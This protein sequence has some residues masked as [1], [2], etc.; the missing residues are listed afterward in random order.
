MFK[1]TLIITLSFHVLLLLAGCFCR[2]S[3]VKMARF[4][5]TDIKFSYADYE[6][7]DSTLFEHADTTA[8]FRG[9]SYL[10]KIGFNYELIAGNQKCRH[11]GLFNEAYACKCDEDRYEQ[12]RMIKSVEMKM[13]TDFDS[14]H[15]RNSTATD[16]FGSPFYSGFYSTAIAGFK[17]FNIDSLGFAEIS[18]RFI[19]SPQF[20]AIPAYLVKKP[21]LDSVQQ[22]EVTV[23]FHDGTT[24]TAT[25]AP[26]RFR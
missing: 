18:E 2:C 21:Q 6:V 5:W 19:V 26:T 17:P 14:R 11:S 25:T 13:L 3:D 7:K 9:K 8:D 23:H 20:F 15:L 4:K 1:K 22:F 10:L 24:Q 12:T 16:L